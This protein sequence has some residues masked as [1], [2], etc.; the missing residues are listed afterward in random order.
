MY[1][2]GG[3]GGGNRRSAE[4]IVAECFGEVCEG[5]TERKSEKIDAS[6]TS[7]IS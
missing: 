6:H 1:K 4:R 3:G 7:T 5:F 2:E